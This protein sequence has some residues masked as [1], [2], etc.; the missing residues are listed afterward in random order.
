LRDL[1][2]D[3]MSNEDLTEFT[4]NVGRVLTRSISGGSLISGI[5]LGVALL[6]GA[7]VLVM[8]GSPGAASPFTQSIMAIA[9]A[10]FA[11]NGRFGEWGGSLFSS[12]GGP[13]SEV[14]MVA[15]RYLTLTFI[16]LL[17]VLALTL[18][19]GSD[20]EMMMMGGGPSPGML[21]LGAFYL[22]AMTLTPPVFLIVSVSAENFA[23]I[24]SPDHWKHLMAGRLGDLFT[25][26]VVY[27][28]ALAM[29]MLLALPPV[30]A[31]FTM[32][33][34]LG[35]VVGGLSF[36]MLFGMSVNLLGRLCGFFSCGEMGEPE[37]AGPKKTEPAPAVSPTPPPAQ[38][39]VESRPAILPLSAAAPPP[40]ARP[41]SGAR[42]PALLDA[43]SRVDRAT[44]RFN[45]DPEGAIAALQGLHESFA[46]VPQVRHA[47]VLCLV[48]AGKIEQAVSMAAAAIALCLERGNSQ[49]AGELFKEMR[50][51]LG[52]IELDAEQLLTVAA[53]LARKQEW[54]AAAK[55]YSSVIDRDNCEIRAI[56]GLLQVADGI[57]NKK[58][59]PPAA[60]KVYRYLMAKCSAS[61]LG[62]QIRQG[63]EAAEGRIR[64]PAS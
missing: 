12:A 54:A 63:L 37:P 26:Y 9:L 34:K 58:G 4:G 22:M 5:V 13:W 36:C 41:Q 3:L 6:A 55:A 35:I 61:P 32:N 51:H 8:A 45:R 31:A 64:Q 10:R 49:L 23:E 14:S 19:V 1:N 43:Q 17:P 28:G 60:A 24:F 7:L 29:V 30:M 38:P 39:R 21:L 46:P 16:W 53:A 2:I 40:T 42:K 33:I 18:K 62:E 15:V 59:H 57:L 11:V 56:Q 27:V 20:P 52:S 47:L 50:P 48:R 25:I 44:D